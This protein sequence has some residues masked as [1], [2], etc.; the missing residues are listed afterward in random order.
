MF[1]L[2][3]EGINGMVLVS[4]WCD[5]QTSIT[6]TKKQFVLMKPFSMHRGRKNKHSNYGHDIW[7]CHYIFFLK[8][9]AIW[10]TCNDN[11]QCK[12]FYDIMIFTLTKITGNEFRK[13][14]KLTES[15]QENKST[16]TVQE[17]PSAVLT[18]GKFTSVTCHFHIKCDF[19]LA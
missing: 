19:Y 1:G 11:L 16:T 2:V 12:W 8:K 7:E 9:D 5:L 13:T 15:Q 18:F 14:L 4:M 10:Y 17:L 6:I 3:V